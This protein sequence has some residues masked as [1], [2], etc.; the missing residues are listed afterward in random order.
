MFDPPDA[1]QFAYLPGRSVD[2]ALAMVQHYVSAG[3]AS[4]PRVTKVAVISLD[5]L[6]GLRYGPEK[7]LNQ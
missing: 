1:N 7:L 5:V 2:D 3:F 4:C 6:E